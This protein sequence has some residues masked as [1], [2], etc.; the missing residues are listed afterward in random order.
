MLF[1]WVDEMF[2]GMCVS[3]WW[4]VGVFVMMLLRVMSYGANVEL[5]V[6]MCCWSYVICCC[7]LCCGWLCIVVS[8]ELGL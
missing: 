4:F 6:G 2:I 1:V 7:W 5:V 8:G 3:G